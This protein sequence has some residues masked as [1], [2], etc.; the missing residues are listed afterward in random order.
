MPFGHTSASIA[1]LYR[2][3]ELARRFGL[4][5]CDA[6]AHLSLVED[7]D[8]ELVYELDFHSRPDA[9][10]TEK[11][12]K[13]DK[14]MEALGCARSGVRTVHLDAMEDIVER[15]ISLAPRP[16]TLG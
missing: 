13:F 10:C 14:M 2:V 6:D 9:P 7:P 12:K 16:R 8:Y 4:R 11:G 3:S 15:A 5:P 1:I